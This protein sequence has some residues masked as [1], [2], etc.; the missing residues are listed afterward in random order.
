ML[1]SEG[2]V[3]DNSESGTP[4]RRELDT[5]ETARAIVD[6][7]SAKMGSDIL[8][9]DLSGVTLIADYFII[10][11]GDSERQLRAMAEDLRLQLKADYAMTPFSAEG[12]PASGW[13][14]LDYGSIVVHLFSEEQR[15]H[16][17]LEQLWS[18]ARTVVRIA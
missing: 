13:L 3:L 7:L 10:L 9:L 14:L 11:T 2:S 4:R 15:Q 8:L 18:S 16:Y 5:L 6:M 12:T 17:Q 1:Y